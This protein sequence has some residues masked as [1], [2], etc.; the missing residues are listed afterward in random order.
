M[1]MHD[2]TDERSGLHLDIADGAEQTYDF[3]RAKDTVDDDSRDR[4]VY[5]A[6]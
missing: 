6:R 2:M 5:F 3:T 1:L 4:H